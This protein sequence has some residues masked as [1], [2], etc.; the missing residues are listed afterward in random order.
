MGKRKFSI[1]GN[2]P[3]SFV[4]VGNCGDPMKMEIKEG[5]EVDITTEKVVFDSR[6]LIVERNLSSLANLLIL[7][8]KSKQMITSNR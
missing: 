5:E 2:I 1:A 6:T 3:I 7:Q 4:V 8:I